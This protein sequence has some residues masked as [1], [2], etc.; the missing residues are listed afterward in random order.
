MHK[1]TR[2]DQVH[3]NL[4]IY[5]GPHQSKEQETDGLVAVILNLDRHG[6]RPVQTWIQAQI[7]MDIGLDRHGYMII[8]TWIQA[9]IYID[10]CLYTLFRV[11]LQEIQFPTFSRQTW[12][13]AQI[14]MYIGLERHGSYRPRK[15]WIIQAWV[16]AIVVTGQDK[17]RLKIYTYVN[18]KLDL[19]G[20]KFTLAYF[21]N[22]LLQEQPTLGIAYFRNSLLQEQ[23][24]LGIAYF[25][26]SQYYRN[27]LL[28]E[29]PTLGIANTIGI[30]YFR[31][32]LLQEQPTIGIAYYRNS[33]LQEQPTIGIAYYRNNPL[34]EHS[35]LQIEPTFGILKPILGR[36]N[37]LWV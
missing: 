20:E 4:C 26:N 7:N 32:S 14:G 29:Q 2:Q 37:Q 21:R 3:A 12:I 8:Q 36:Y 24:T 17:T 23:L 28:Q 13:E 27:S 11:F 22:S 19:K 6:C 1:A 25:R 16:R 10:I 15:A 35:P 33:L 31:N 34:Q 5:I 30:A 18:C 9:Q